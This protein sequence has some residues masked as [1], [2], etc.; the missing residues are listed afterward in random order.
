MSEKIKITN[1]LDWDV[2]RTHEAVS[3]FPEAALEQLAVVGLDRIVKDADLRAIATHAKSR[4]GEVGSMGEMF[5]LRDTDDIVMKVH[6]HPFSYVGVNAALHEGLAAHRQFSTPNYLGTI[7]S[8]NGTQ[9]TLMTREPGIEL[10]RVDNKDRSKYERGVHALL[11]STASKALASVGV[12][13]NLA[14]WDWNHNN[15]LVPAATRDWRDV[16]NVPITI[17]D[18]QATQIGTIDDWEKQARPDFSGVARDPRDLATEQAADDAWARL[19]QSQ[20]L[21]KN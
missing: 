13:P 3:A 14:H 1:N 21:V 6:K 12:D 17:L 19:N 9:A 8:R 2:T 4:M 18:Q 7:M 16:H 10:S 11:Q 5:T 15:L 20:Q